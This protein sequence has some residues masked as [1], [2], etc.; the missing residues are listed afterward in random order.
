MPAHE[1]IDQSRECLR[2]DRRAPAR[3]IRL[4]EQQA[5]ERIEPPALCITRQIAGR[6]GDHAHVGHGAVARRAAR[7]RCSRAFRRSALLEL[8]RQLVNGVEEQRAARGELELAGQD[9]RSGSTP[10]GRRPEV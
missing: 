3:A 4:R 8:R 10:C 5:E 6:R 7:S 9:E 1:V 2:A